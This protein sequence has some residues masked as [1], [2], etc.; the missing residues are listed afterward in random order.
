MQVIKE[1][2]SK[3]KL[4]AAALITFFIGILLC[5]NWTGST[6]EG[7]ERADLSSTNELANRQSMENP[8]GAIENPLNL[9]FERRQFRSMLESIS[10]DDLLTMVDDSKDDSQAIQAAFEI[11]GRELA[12]AEFDM[13]W[14]IETIENRLQLT[15]PAWWQEFVVACTPNPGTG[16][17]R[18]PFDMYGV[19]KRIKRTPEK[20]FEAYCPADS[21]LVW[22]A[23]FS[24]FRFSNENVSISIPLSFEYGYRSA[25]FAGTFSKDHFFMAV[26]DDTVF[27]HQI[28]CFDRSSNECILHSIAC[29]SF[30]GSCSGFDSA[31]VRIHLTKD[32]RVFV[33]GV[34]ATGFYLHGFDIDTGESLVQLSTR[35][36]PEW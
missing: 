30:I 34:A 20:M 35:Y 13:E 23:D 15:I 3:W 6:H 17:R 1:I 2:K 22:N 19:P 7:K 29:G 14:L 21:D 5:A 36:S 28:W 26:Y 32:R 12:P 10:D 25:S 8:L 9:F 33:F 11:V 16:Q 31:D 18:T 24:R 27:P 4:A